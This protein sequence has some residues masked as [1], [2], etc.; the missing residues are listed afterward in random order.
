MEETRFSI[1]DRVRVKEMYPDGHHRTTYF[2]K[3]KDRF[4]QPLFRQIQES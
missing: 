3:G 4:N 2:V 1:G